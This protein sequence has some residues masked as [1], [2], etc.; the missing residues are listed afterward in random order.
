MKTTSTIDFLGPLS[1]EK[2]V[3]TGTLSKVQE[4]IHVTFSLPPVSRSISE[5]MFQF[6][7]ADIPCYLIFGLAIVIAILV[8]LLN[9]H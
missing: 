4:I 1:S 8:P 6:D 2:V 7:R 3:R 5:D 9:L